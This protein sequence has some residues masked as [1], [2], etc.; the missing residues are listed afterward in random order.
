METQ[1]YCQYLAGCLTYVYHLNSLDFLLN[2]AE[3]VE[4]CSHGSARRHLKS[5]PFAMGRFFEWLRSGPN[6]AFSNS[7]STCENILS[8]RCC[9]RM[10]S[11]RGSASNRSK[12]AVY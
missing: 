7:A 11:P 12:V 9:E 6:A 8:P 5:S 3:W 10:D 2:V 4:A 1:I